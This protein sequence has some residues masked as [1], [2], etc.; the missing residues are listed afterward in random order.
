MLHWGLKEVMMNEPDI[1]GMLTTQ[2]AAE[3]LQVN[4]Q[5]IRQRVYRRTLQADASINGRLYFKPETLREHQRQQGE[6]YL[7]KSIAQRVIPKGKPD[8]IS[9][10]DWDMLLLYAKEGNSLTDVH[11]EYGISRQ[12]AHQRIIRTIARLEHY[13][14]VEQRHRARSRGRTAGTDSAGGGRSADAG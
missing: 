1:S 3:R 12:R 10:T 11:V 7:T 9:Q 13:R 8:L 4:P 14:L 6:R 2:E 5:A